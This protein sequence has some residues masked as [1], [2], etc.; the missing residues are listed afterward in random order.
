[1]D[2]ME[3]KTQYLYYLSHKTELMFQYWL[4][5]MVAKTGEI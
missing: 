2:A 3:K 5:L 4:M 1:M